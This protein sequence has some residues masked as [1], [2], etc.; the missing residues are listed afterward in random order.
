MRFFPCF[1][2]LTMVIK[3]AT[4]VYELSFY[5]TRNFKLPVCAAGVRSSAQ[6]LV[7]M[8]LGASSVILREPLAGALEAPSGGKATEPLHHPHSFLVFAN[9]WW[10]FIFTLSWGPFRGLL[11]QGLTNGKRPFRF[12]CIF[13][14]FLKQIQGLVHAVG[15]RYGSSRAWERQ[16]T[17]PRS[18]ATTV[19]HKS[20][21]VLWTSEEH[22]VLW[23]WVLLFW[24]LYILS[25]TKSPLR[26]L[27]QIQE[28]P[29]WAF[30][31]GTFERG[32]A[33]I[34]HLWIGQNEASVLLFFSSLRLLQI[35]K[36]QVKWEPF[37]CISSL[38]FETVSDK[39]AARRCRSFTL[40][41]KRRP[42]GWNVGYRIVAWC[43]FPL[44]GWFFVF[45]GPYQ[46]DLKRL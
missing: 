43:C 4:M 31:F 6:A 14:E 35:G 8:S 9:F 13:L 33:S 1:R 5:V 29:F 15:V 2:L 19:P 18:V 7:A 30:L 16:I 26:L 27:K 38:A 39:S 45:V 41:S 40:A 12:F 10:C 37:W 22:G 24:G 46:K 20:H 36:S 28:K 42:W 21:L 44:L 25:L 23:T 3:E 11:C 34:W 32:W 17:I